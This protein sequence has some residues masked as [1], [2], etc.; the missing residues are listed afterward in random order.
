MVDRK[1]CN[2]NNMIAP[3]P[4]LHGHGGDER[5]VLDSAIGFHVTICW[6]SLRLGPPRVEMTK[7]KDD[8]I[9]LL[10]ARTF[11]M[12]NILREYY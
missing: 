3:E 4:M 12:Q 2:E 10:R 6:E 5:I 1:V 7:S 11:S 8:N 9:L